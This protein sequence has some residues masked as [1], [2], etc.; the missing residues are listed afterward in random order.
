MKICFKCNTEKPLSKYYKHQQMGDGHLNKCKDC[1]KEDVRKRETELRKDPAWVEKE[2]ERGRDKY[3]RLG[4]KKPSYEQKKASMDRYKEKYPEKYNAK[5]RS[6]KMKPKIKGNQ[7]HHWSYNDEHFKDTI[8]LSLFNHSLVHRF[9][10]YDQERKMYR[11]CT[12]LLID[13]REAA[14]NYY[15]ELGVEIK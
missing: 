3:R 13:S 5:I 6:Q 12:G 9:T 7:M 8:E 15:K 14:L 11:T 2:K 1:T 10:V 4:C